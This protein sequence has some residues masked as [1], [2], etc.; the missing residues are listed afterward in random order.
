MQ[1]ISWEPRAFLLH[2]FLSDEECDHLVALSEGKMRKSSVVD[3]ETGGSVDSQA[4]T[5]T[6]TFLRYKEDEIVARIEKR[7]SMVTMLPEE[8][9]ETLQILRYINGQKYDP[10]TG[11]LMAQFA[12][13]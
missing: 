13:Q 8:N 4:R 3:G 1:Q 7:I 6:G 11:G 5:S 9:G 2:S 12:T 10:H